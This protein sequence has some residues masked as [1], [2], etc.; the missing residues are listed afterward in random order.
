MMKRISHLFSPVSA[1]FQKLFTV[2]DLQFT[3]YDFQFSAPWQLY[4]QTSIPAE[5]GKSVLAQ[6]AQHQYLT[7]VY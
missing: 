3:V 5:R 1:R 4:C 7:S 6:S 2:Y